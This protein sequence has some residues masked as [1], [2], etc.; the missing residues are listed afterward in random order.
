MRIGIDG[1]NLEMAHGTGVSTYGFALAEAIRSLGHEVDGFF[2]LDVGKDAALREVLFFDQIARDEKEKKR[3]GKW[4]RRLNQVN[5][6][7]RNPHAR[8]IGQTDLV[9]RET[10]ASRLPRFDRLT[11]SPHLFEVAHRHFRRFGRFLRLRVEN[12]PA[13]MHWTYPVPIEMIGSRNVYTLH[14]M[15]PLRLPYTTLDVKADYNRLIRTCIRRADHICTVS[16][17]SRRDILSRFEINPDIVTN[18]YQSSP[19]PANAISP[20]PADDA[21]M[22]D[23]IFGFSHRGYFL[24]FG[25]IEPKKNVGRII[26]AY[27]GTHSNHVLVIVGAR[28]W[29]S[30]GELKLIADG[31]H[32]RMARQVVRLDYLPRSLLLRLIRGAR[33]VIFPSLYEGFGLPVLEAMQ[34]GTPVL[35]SETSSLPEVAGDAAKLVNPYSAAAITEAWREIDADDRLR[36]HMSAAGLRQAARFS[37]AEYRKRLAA[38]YDRIAA[39]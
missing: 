38:M 20:D 17:S 25:A 23:G 24:F 39:G 5:A 21:R 8:E 1:Y 12:P 29:Q 26:E 18:T 33:A 32:G 4:S 28:A 14:D 19:F 15:V 37:D 31:G 13:I 36:E 7:F 35:T 16:D 10:F 22:I 9:Q 11:S 30:E 6:L 34:L 27:L 2:G 3:S